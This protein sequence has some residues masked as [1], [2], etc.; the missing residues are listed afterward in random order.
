MKNAKN[1]TKSIYKIPNTSIN[2]NYLSSLRFEYK[3]ILDEYRILSPEIVER[4]NG[5]QYIANYILLM[6]AVVASI[7]QS[8]Q[9]IDTQDG[10]IRL[11]RFMLLFFSL[12]FFSFVQ[13][14]GKFSIKHNL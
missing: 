13:F 12:I 3:A 4:I 6:L 10:F 1:V 8:F 5:Q 11:P 14:F 9:I 2:N 7:N